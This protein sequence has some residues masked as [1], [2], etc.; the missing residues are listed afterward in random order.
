MKSL[1]VNDYDMKYVDIGQGPPLVC[2]HGSTNDFRDW[3]MVMG[4][5]SAR[6]RLIVP[7]LRHYFPEVWNG[8]GGSFTMAQHVDDMI[9]LIEGL[10]LGPVDLVGHSRGGHLSFRLALQRPELVRKLVLAEPGGT[11]DDSLMPPGA[12]EANPAAAARTYI[13]DASEKIGAGDLEGGLRV[14]IDGISGPGFW[15]ALPAAIRQMRLDNAYTLLAQV[16]EERRPYA[17]S[18]AQALSVPTLFIGGADTQGMLPIVLEQLA[19][20]VPDAQKVMIADAAHPMFRQQ[21]AAFCD[22]VLSFLAD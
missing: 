16:N 14:F 5:L 22:A 10:Q 20:N 8:R 21:P 13:K 6:N 7:S 12:A 15:D 18:E 2:V 19:A 1:R 9:G 17:R 11:L 4:P 3:A